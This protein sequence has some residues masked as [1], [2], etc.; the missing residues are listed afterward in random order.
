[1]VV[2]MMFS[3]LLFNKSSINSPA[4]AP[5][6][7]G[8]CLTNRNSEL[9]SKIIFDSAKPVSIKFSFTSGFV[10]KDAKRKISI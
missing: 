7:K 10:S 4:V 9:M 8:F 1:M 2:P 6:L 3:D 5:I